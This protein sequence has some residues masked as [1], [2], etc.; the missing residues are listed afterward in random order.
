MTMCVVCDQAPVRR[1]LRCPVPLLRPR[2]PAQYPA[3]GPPR[4]PHV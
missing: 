3:R 2:H 4:G 1:L